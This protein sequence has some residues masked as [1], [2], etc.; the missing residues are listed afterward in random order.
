MLSNDSTRHNFYS[1]SDCFRNN[2]FKVLYCF[3]HLDDSF[4]R[5]DH[6]VSQRIR[7]FV[8]YCH[9]ELTFLEVWG[10][11][12]FFNFWFFWHVLIFFFFDFF[13]IFFLY[14]IT[15]LGVNYNLLG[16]HNFWNLISNFLIF[17]VIWWLLE[18]TS[19]IRVLPLVHRLLHLLKSKLLFSHYVRNLLSNLLLIGLYSN[20]NFNIRI[21]KVFSIFNFVCF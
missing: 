14:L 15:I 5:R 7:V 4:Q 13:I 6:H 21:L 20:I 17:F 18:S 9:A 8:A 10:T 11:I 3:V 12:N 19:N 1:R 2:D 16:I